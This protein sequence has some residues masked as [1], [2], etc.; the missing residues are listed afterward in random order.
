MAGGAGL[1]DGL[2][3]GDGEG[4]GLG[5]GDGDG[6]GDAAGLGEGL[7][8]GV[9]DGLGLGDGAAGG[10]L[11]AALGGGDGAADG[12]A[13]GA[14][15]G[16]ADGLGFGDP[17]GGGVKSW[18]EFSALPLASS[19]PAMRSWPFGSN[20]VVCRSR[21][22]SRS[23]PSLQ[24]SVVELYSSIV[25]EVA[26]SVWMPPAATGLPKSPPTIATRPSGNAVAV[27]LVRGVGSEAAPVQV[28]VC[29][30]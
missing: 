3:L 25:E 22:W 16:A 6:L 1:G 29:G 26:A 13:L 2:G 10:G 28:F 24:V 4:E 17:G 21:G 30:L 14:A 8:A 19:P 27:W 18:V 15:L 5:D 11:G 7:P 23:P 20:V 12:A 9:G